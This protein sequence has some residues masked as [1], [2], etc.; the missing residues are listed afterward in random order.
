MNS[1]FSLLI[2]IMFI[3]LNSCK[4][5]SV[6]GL[7]HLHQQ[8]TENLLLLKN[9]STD[10]M[11]VAIRKNDTTG[12]R[13]AFL[14]L[15]NT[16]KKIEAPLEYFLPGTARGLNGPA[17]TEVEAE[18][19]KE[20]EPT[21][22]QVMETFIYPEYHPEDSSELIRACRNF[23]AMV[24]RALQLWE[25]TTPKEA[26]WIDAA[27]FELI[28]I[29]TLG[30]TGFDT[31]LCQE[32][33]KESHTAL[34]SV[35]DI[36]FHLKK[37]PKSWKGYMDTAVIM[38]TVKSFA[39]FDRAAFLRG[40]YKQLFESLASIRIKNNAVVNNYAMNPA[41]KNIFGDGFLNPDFFAPD[42]LVS[43]PELADLGRKLFF[44]PMLSLNG[45]HSCASCHQPEK[46][47][48]DQLALSENIHGNLLSRNTPGLIN[49]AFQTSYF[50]D[51]RVMNLEMQA[52]AVIENANE[53]HGSI[54]QVAQKLNNN[55][56][57]KQSF[58]AA[59]GGDPGTTV[60]PER[61][62]TA[63]A[64]FQRTLST[65]NSPFDRYML[66]LDSAVDENVIAGFNLFTG[67]AKCATCHFLPTFSGL[68]PPYYDKMESE[69]IGTP[70]TANNKLKDK[71][72]GRFAIHPV[73]AWENSFKTPTVRNIEFTFPYMHN[74]VYN[75]LEQVV[76]FYNAGGGLGLGLDYPNQTLAPDSLHLT[77]IE[78][79]QL[80][81]FMKSLSGKLPF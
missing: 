35:E 61:I 52:N 4:T 12:I 62:T 21:G 48:T 79:N 71:D 27:Y 18:E 64:A 23:Q 81:Y 11:L 49:T 28:R 57:W 7:N 59:F 78:K 76:D 3:L 6:G 66:G 31:P 58:F 26:Q 8:V 56:K 60:S 47:Y 33:V 75:T 54:K 17:I 77:T 9:T 63:L 1:K 29:A 42:S 41:A 40:P 10:N 37:L 44:S 67:K 13:M 69:V 65:F 19:H 16:Y 25:V 45:K 51:M 20:S 24:K 36:L 32:A 68:V 30:I 38:M 5:S 43:K 55:S 34:K 39:E 70:A 15:R 73:P 80:I 46:F 53:M 14:Q 72:P 50:W 22:L 2:C 74:G